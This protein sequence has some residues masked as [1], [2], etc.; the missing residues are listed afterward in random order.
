MQSSAKT[1]FTQEMLDA[2]ADFRAG[3]LEQCFFHLERAHILGQRYFR[4]HVIT[5]WWMLKVGV[6]Q[7]RGQEIRGQILRLIATVPGYFFGWIP[8]G[9]TGGANVSPLK[10]MP[11]PEDLAPHLEDFIVARDVVRRM[12][13]WALAVGLGVLWIAAG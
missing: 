13:F 10:P 1:A 8:K 7:R 3:A 5:H 4:A 9:N 11:L 6:R 12:A 2:R